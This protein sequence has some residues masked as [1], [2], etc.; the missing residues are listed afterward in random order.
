MSARDDTKRPSE[1]SRTFWQKAEVLLLLL[2]IDSPDWRPLEF[3]KIPRHTVYTFVRDGERTVVEAKSE[4]SAS[5][6]ARKIR[7]DPREYPI[8]TWRWKVDKLVEKEDGRAKSG[9]D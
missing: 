1:R 4:A 9:D 3:A 8:V 7:I 6:I 2:A 5:G